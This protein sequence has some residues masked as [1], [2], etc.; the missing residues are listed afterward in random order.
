[1][2]TEV[3]G[4]GV[5]PDLHLMQVHFLSKNMFFPFTLRGIPH[6]ISASINPAAN[7]PAPMVYIIRLSMQRSFAFAAAL[8][9]AIPRSMYLKAH[10]GPL[11]SA[12]TSVCSI[13]SLHVGKP[14]APQFNP[15][16][17]DVLRPMS[18]TASASL[19]F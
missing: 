19:T 6:A 14:H 16:G 1:M 10:F 5:F 9:S 8:P 12:L 13:I 3:R 4:V 7:A 18:I 17:S 2:N 11:K 15:D